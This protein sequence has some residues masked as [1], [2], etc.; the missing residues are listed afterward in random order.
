ML[1]RAAWTDSAERSARRRAL[2]LTLT[3]WLRG[4]GPKATPP[5]RRCGTL[6]AP[7]RARPVPFWR[8]ALAPSSSRPRRGRASRRC[9][10]GAAARSARA[11][12][13]TSDSWKSSAKTRGRQVG[14]GGLAQHG[15]LRGQPS[16][17][18][19]TVPPF[20]PGTAPRTSSRLSLGVDLDHLEAALGDA[21]AAHPAGHL[22]ALEDARGV[23]A[24][25]DRAGR[26]DVVRA[27]RDRA[28]ARSR[29]GG[30]CPGSPCRSPVAGD[31]DQL[32]RPRSRSR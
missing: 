29:G 28:A 23:G 21:L 18:T 24:G 3:V 9:R 2:R 26:A 17:R 15:S 4:L 32:A 13:W 7:T 1:P 14:L 31:L 5:P 12:S 10:G 20:G 11:V 30:S 25:A 16:V 19:S 8:Q 6:S 22:H 27:V